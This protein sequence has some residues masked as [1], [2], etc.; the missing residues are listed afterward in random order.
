LVARE[1][2]GVEMQHQLA[3]R[4]ARCVDEVDA[5]VAFEAVRLGL[6]LGVQRVPRP[7]RRLICECRGAGAS[8]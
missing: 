6:E 3:E 4:G 8:Q 5:N 2:V 7:R 1:C